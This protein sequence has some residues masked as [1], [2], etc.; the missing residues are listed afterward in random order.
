MEPVVSHV[1]P[2]SRL[3]I[4]TARQRGAIRSVISGVLISIV[5]L[6]LTGGMGGILNYRGEECHYYRTFAITWI[7][8]EAFS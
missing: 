3:C 4:E 6:Y 8:R 2:F 5:P 1:I 7:D